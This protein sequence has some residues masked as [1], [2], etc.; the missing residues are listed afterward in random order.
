MPGAK[1]FVPNK[2]LIQEMMS[3]I[4]EN[5]TEFSETVKLKR[6][7]K[8]LSVERTG[9]VG[10]CPRCGTVRP[11]RLYWMEMVPGEII[12][13]FCKRCLLRAAQKMEAED[14]M[15]MGVPVYSYPTSIAAVTQALLADRNRLSQTGAQ[16][17]PC[18]EGAL[19]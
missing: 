13:P 9:R 8:D 6:G 12:G 15:Q 10:K 2:I 16:E 7:G 3:S 19:F 17:E 11:P 14:G 5:S 4:C 18:D 1:S